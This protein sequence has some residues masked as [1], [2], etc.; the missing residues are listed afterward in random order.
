MLLKKG[1]V[2]IATDVQ[3]DFLPGGSL[4]ITNGDRVITPLNTAIRGFS[5]QGLPVVAT[6]DWHPQNHSSFFAQGGRW[7]PHCVAESFGA[8]F[9]ERLELPEGVVVISKATD[10]DKEAYSAFEGT[11]LNAQLRSLG[12]HRIVIGGLATDYCV[13]NTVKDALRLG[14]KVYVLEDAI[15]AIN[16]RPD[17]G[18]RALRE[19]ERLGAVLIRSRDLSVVKEEAA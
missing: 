4:P 5:S 10:R 16:A 3:H 18:L 1:D 8:H 6:R 19:M 9:D 13:L 17:D 15:E 7:P 12:A 11:D 14:Y 2:L